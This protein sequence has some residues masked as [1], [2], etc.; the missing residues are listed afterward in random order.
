M[1]WETC[2]C[3][4]WFVVGSGWSQIQKFSSDGLAEVRYQLM[5]IMRQVWLTHS[6]SHG[7]WSSS[8]MKFAEKKSSFW[9]RS[10]IITV[11]LIAACL[12]VLV[13]I[14]ELATIVG[15]EHFYYSS[16]WPSRVLKNCSV[17]WKCTRK[18]WAD[19]AC[20]G[21]L[22]LEYGTN[23]Q[24]RIADGLIWSRGGEYWN[25]VK[26]WMNRTIVTMGNFWLASRNS[27]K[28]SNDKA[29]LGRGTNLI[30]EYIHL[31]TFCLL[32][33]STQEVATRLFYK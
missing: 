20:Q 10:D 24:G 8:T 19:V 9:G 25:W 17:K 30:F 12:L 27:R 18:E 28:E 26:V 15:Q 6:E 7:F 16:S 21:T 3:V 2:L 33:S 31:Y 22:C 32:L 29:I 14:V 5:V 23:D 13:P 4:L 1:I 11:R